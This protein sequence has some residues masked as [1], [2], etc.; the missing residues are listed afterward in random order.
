[1]CLG[2]V[3]GQDL[4]VVSEILHS[5]DE[6]GLGHV[7]DFRAQGELDTVPQCVTFPIQI[8]DLLTT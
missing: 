5:T 3:C 4:I 8:L 1:M 2:E 6:I 7:V